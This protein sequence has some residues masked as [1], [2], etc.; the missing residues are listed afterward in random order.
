MYIDILT[1]M[2]VNICCL[3]KVMQVAFE[4]NAWIETSISR[5]VEIRLLY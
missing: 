3:F 1:W 5:S 4:L 2:G